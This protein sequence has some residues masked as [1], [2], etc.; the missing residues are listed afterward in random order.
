MLLQEIKITG[1][2][3]EEILTKIKP[4]YEFM[5][6]DAKGSVGGIAILWNPTEVTVDYSIGMKMILT[7][8]F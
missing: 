4:T 7:G 8:R 6:I 1:G 3:M 2:K 5:I